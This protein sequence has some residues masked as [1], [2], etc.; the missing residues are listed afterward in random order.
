[1]FR[2]GKAVEK[3]QRGSVNVQAS[4]SFL[5]TSQQVLMQLCIGVSLSLAIAGI[6]QRI[7]C[8]VDNGCEDEYDLSCCSSISQ[9]TCPGM[10]IGDFVTVLSYTT[11]IFIP[12]NFLGSVYNMVVMSLIDLADLSTLLAENPDV[13]DS[14]DAISLPKSN[15]SNPSDT[16]EFENVVFRYPSQHEGAGLKGISFKMKKGT[17]TG[18]IVCSIY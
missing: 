15:T 13:T 5:N 3:F 6:K 4:L 7:D 10:N 12:L 8:C 17:T 18:K 9:Q 14:S 11:Q 2:F 16:V 1:M